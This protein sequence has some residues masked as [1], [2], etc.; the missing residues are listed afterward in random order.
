MKENKALFYSFFEYLEKQGK[1]YKKK[2]I[3]YKRVITKKKEKRK[4][5]LMI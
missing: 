5:I 4:I 2:E 1:N 3:I